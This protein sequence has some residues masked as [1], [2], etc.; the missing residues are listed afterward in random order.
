MRALPVLV[1]LA[2]C[3]G[4]PSVAHLADGQTAQLVYTLD[5]NQ[6]AL[7]ESVRERLQRPEVVAVADMLDRDH[8]TVDDEAD[9]VICREHLWA[10]PSDLSRAFE[11][12]A[13]SQYFRLGVVATT[14]DAYLAAERDAQRDALLV[15]DCV[16]APSI[17]NTS[18]RDFVAGPLRDH[19]A[20]HV[21][22]VDDVTSTP[23]AI[24]SCS[25]LC[26]DGTLSVRVRR[27]ACE[28]N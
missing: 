6:M 27:A 2:G 21:Q 19:L 25:A 22:A 12:E 4:A 24:P 20:S 16:I 8:A 5:A 17:E 10:R 11:D 14:D 3:N 18:L 1:V 23:A 26:D 28:A 7:A 9:S 13:L 15:F